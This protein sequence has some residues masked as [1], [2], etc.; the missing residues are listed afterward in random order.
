MD[1]PSFYSSKEILLLKKRIMTQEKSGI[2]MGTAALIAG[3]PVML[4]TAPFG[5]FYVF[6]NLIQYNNAAVTTQNL[7]AHPALFISGIFAMLITFI[8]DIVLAWALYIFFKPINPML[9]LLGAW[10]R[11]I[12]AALAI[13]ALYNFLYAFHIA[14]MPGIDETYRQQQV[15]QFVNARLFGMRLAYVIF[16]LYLILG[17]VLALM[18]T[19]IPRLLGIMVILAGVSWILTSIQPYFFKGYKLSWVM[20]FGLGELVFGVWLLIWGRKVKEDSSG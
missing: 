1:N 12:Y 8:Y 7:V 6:G 15:L 5:E 11:L 17:G 18:S 20:I 14:N 4:F 2:S 9:S 10:L 3:F 13:V 16:G 19:Y